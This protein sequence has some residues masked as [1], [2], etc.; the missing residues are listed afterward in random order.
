[1]NGTKKIYA[2]DSD[3]VIMFKKDNTEIKNWIEN[4]EF[5]NEE[6]EYFDKIEQKILRN[7]T[8]NQFI[9]TSKRNTTLEL[10]KLYR[11]ENNMSKIMECDNI[12]CDTY[13]LNNHEQNRRTYLEL[14][15]QLN[16]LKMK[17]YEDLLE[18]NLR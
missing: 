11:Y 7:T 14:L 4:L 5:V 8:I 6:L 2:T 1:M 12:Q 17:I 10:S 15:V 13:Y 9:K 3:K 16:S 18:F